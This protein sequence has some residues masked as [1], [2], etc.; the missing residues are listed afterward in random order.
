MLC[1]NLQS[2]ST[3]SQEDEKST[4]EEVSE[5]AI[6]IDQPPLG[7]S[8]PG[9]QGVELPFQSH[10]QS[11]GFGLNKSSSSPEL[12][13]LPEAFSKVLESDASEAA[14]FSDAKPQVLPPPSE[15]DGVEGG[16][17]GDTTDG[18]PAPSHKGEGSAPSSQGGGAALRLPLPAAQSAT[19]SPGGGHRPRGHTISVSAPSR[20]D[21]RAE[22]DSYH[23][24]AGPSPT[25][26][27]SGLS[28]RYTVGGGHLK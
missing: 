21:R 23:G 25:E 13:T 20:R 28:P 3:S 8:T 26:K 5:G 27:A 10:S 11:Q 12:Q 17:G 16:S 2:S 7:P 4:L 15:K 22:R 19:I 6:P 24:R 14:A 18:L 1:S 9:S